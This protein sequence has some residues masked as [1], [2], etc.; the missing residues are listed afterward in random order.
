MKL[1]LSI[2]IFVISMLLGGCSGSMLAEEPLDDTWSDSGF[3]QIGSSLTIENSDNRFTLLE[4]R[5][6][7]SAEGLYYATW[8]IGDPIP[9]ENSEGDTVNL[10]DAHLYLLLGEYSSGDHAA[11]NMQKWL[12]AGK[13]NYEVITEEEITCRQQT[14]TLITYQFSDSDNPYDRGISVFGSCHKSSVC[15]ELTCRETFTEDLRP[16]IITFLEHCTFQTN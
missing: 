11:E 14:Y 4:N 6:T 10:Y 15:I 5:N 13:N 12:S 2:C 1:K 7:L 9:Y 16:L 3:V 8:T